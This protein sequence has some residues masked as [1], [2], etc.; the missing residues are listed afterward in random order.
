MI[1]FAVPGN[2]QVQLGIPDTA[3][4]KIINLNIDSIEAASMWKEDCNTNIGNAKELDIRQETH[5]A[6]KSYTNMDKNLS[7]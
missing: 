7:H 5:V 6:K 1:F 4:L 3:T 2:G